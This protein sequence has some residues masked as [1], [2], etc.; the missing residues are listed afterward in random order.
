MYTLK[1]TFS[2]SPLNMSI[3]LPCLKSISAFIYSENRHNIYNFNMSDDSLP[4]PVS[5][6]SEIAWDMLQET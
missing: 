6:H 2:A 3:R 4:I 5:F 1:V